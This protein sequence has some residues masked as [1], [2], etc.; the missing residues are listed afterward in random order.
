MN[1]AGSSCPARH[2]GRAKTQ[3][4]HFGKQEKLRQHNTRTHTHSQEPTFRA[5]PRLHAKSSAIFLPLPSSQL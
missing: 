3:R 1:N 4:R 2:D 5:E